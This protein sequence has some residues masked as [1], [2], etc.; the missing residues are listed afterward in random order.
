[1]LQP[2]Y[3]VYDARLTIHQKLMALRHLPNI[4]PQTFSDSL[5]M[6]PG[7]R[8]LALQLL[9]GGHLIEAGVH[10]GEAGVH[11]GKLPS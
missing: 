7:L 8:L 10:L 11:L 9:P 5:E 1:V 4:S 6:A 2:I 3:T